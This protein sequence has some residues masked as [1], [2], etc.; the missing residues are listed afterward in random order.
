MK[1]TELPSRDLL[2]AF[3]SPT[4]T[5]G[6]G[7][8]AALAGAL[9]AS[10]WRWSAAMPKT[11]RDRGGRR[12]AAGGG[13][14]LRAISA[15][16]EALVDDDSDAYDAVVAA[17]R[18]PKA[19]DDEKADAD[20]GD[21]GGA[22]LA[23]ETPLEAM[24]QCR[25]AIEAA[26]AVASFGNANAASDVGVGRRAAVAA[27]AGR[28][29]NVEINLESLRRDVRRA[30]SERSRSDSSA[31]GGSGFAGRTRE[32][33]MTAAPQ[34]PAAAA[35]AGWPAAQASA[36]STPVGGARASPRPRP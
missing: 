22:E 26:A 25:E 5:P 2:A 7:S 28:A 14:T 29:P 15:T 19:I 4:P 21:S 17:Y 11:A 34:L 33:S 10:C 12:T 24:R 3:R 23:T 32:A 6:G 31:D 8:A 35:T 27:A 20:G 16:A 13:L 9:G 30:V 36:G 18:L 1:L